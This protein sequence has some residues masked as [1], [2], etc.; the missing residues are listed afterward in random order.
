M[1]PLCVGILTSRPVRAQVDGDPA[2][3]ERR[4][5]VESARDMACAI[6]ALGHEAAIL[7]VATADELVRHPK[8]PAVDL[9]MV[10][11]H[12]PTG[13][14]GRL[15]EVLERL[16][17]PYCAPASNAI[18]GAFDKLAARKCLAQHGLPV[19]TTVVLSS[20]SEPNA[21]AVAMLGW[22]CVAKPRHG[23]HGTE[24]A[25]LR[26]EAAV[27]DLVRRGA[28]T[29]DDI[30]LERGI[31]G[32]EVQVVLLGEQVLGA[33]EVHRAAGEPA[34]MMVCPPQFG[35]VVLDGIYALARRA[36][37]ALDLHASLARVDLLCSPR[38]NECIL[39]VEPLPPVHRRGVAARVAAAAGLSY[40]QLIA[41]MLDHMALP[42]RPT[43]AGHREAPLATYA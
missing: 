34:S 14:S 17:I 1:R 37:A 38:Q 5:D 31:E 2:A 15:V 39:E 43:L 28:P 25:W 7:E 21:R 19:P 35:Q 24:V 30:L 3:V 11:A 36:V 13:G 26:D 18:A 29:S 20:D 4:V 40:E 32:R 22:P 9:C 6:R 10:A 41:R 12:G 16:G 8:I 27:A 33:M 42:A 23:A